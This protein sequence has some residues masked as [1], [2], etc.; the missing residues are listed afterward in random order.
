MHIALLCATQR[1]L[2]V[3]TKLRGLAP[4]A[5][6][7]VFSF[8]ADP[9]E[10]AFFGDI[11]AFCA[12]EQLELVKTRQVGAAEH[13][14]LWRETPPDLLLCVNWRY[15]VPAEVFNTVGIG[16]FVLHD[17]LLPGYRGF[18]PTVW[19]VAN[20]ERQTGVTLFQMG[21]GMDDGAI[22]DQLSVAIG[23]DD[24]IAEVTER[25]TAGCLELLERAW[26]ALADGSFRLAPQ[27]LTRV[28]YPAKRLPEDNRIDWSAP[29]DEIHRLVRAVSRPYPGAVTTLRG[30]KLTI[31]RAERVVSP[32]R[33]VG[34]VPGRVVAIQ[35]GVGTTVLTGDGELVLQEVQLEGGQPVPAEELIG[36]VRDTLGA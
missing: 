23:S 7:S 16:A 18:S 36:S 19:A 34:R 21:E 25:V 20:G 35:P 17:S 29:S 24:Y 1:G 33:F 2:R 30:R 13:A 9:W 27:D 5:R 3:L 12:R 32:R 28:T 26:P 31:W 4:D 22:V 14:H 11:A 15:L 6:L 10:P 8:E